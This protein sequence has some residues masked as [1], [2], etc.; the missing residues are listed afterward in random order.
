MRVRHYFS[1]HAQNFFGA[2]GRIARQPVSSLMT[3]VVIAIALALPAGLRVMLNN[4]QLLSGSWEGVIDFTVY[5]DVA[6]GIDRAE[7]LA[8][9]IGSRPSVSEVALVTREQALDEFR[10]WSGFGEAL[11]ALGE[12]PLPHALVVRPATDNSGEI[13]ILVGDIESAAG[14]D[15]V[16]LDTAWVERLGAIL[17]LVRRAIDIA[18]ALL[19]F[20]VVLVIGNTIRL[21]INTRRDEIEV[22][23]LVGGSDAFVR[24]P[25]LYTGFLFGLTGGLV[26]AVTVALCLQLI[27]SPTRALAELY[28]SAFSLAGLTLRQT[29][30]LLGGGAA[31]GWAG[32]ALSA[33][34]HL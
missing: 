32:A 25:F 6:T 3:I 26:A 17:T 29:A 10:S 18:T 23:K 11:D 30:V 20:A 8:R 21:E 28:G 13:D 34:R 1:L 24:R 33:G 14:V 9:E 15:F 19:G 5:L 4:A 2:I 27:A 16:Q 7:E 12:N 31:L 22:T